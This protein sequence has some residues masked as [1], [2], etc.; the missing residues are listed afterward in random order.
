MHK[1][2]ATAPSKSG[3]LVARFQHLGKLL[4]V[5]MCHKLENLMPAK[6]CSVRIYT[7]G[8][9]CVITLEL[10]IICAALLPMRM[11]CK[12]VWHHTPLWLDGDQI[13]P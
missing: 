2:L 9:S 8:N 6:V 11:V 7:N 12:V 5:E 3:H 10:C 4:C 1:G 13:F